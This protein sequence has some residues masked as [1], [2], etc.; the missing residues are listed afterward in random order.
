MQCNMRVNYIINHRHESHHYIYLI[1]WFICIECY[2][3][4]FQR[5]DE[6][7]NEILIRHKPD[8]RCTK[9]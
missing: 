4:T 8:A 1:R 3:H 6:V 5:V 7:A 9:N 2:S